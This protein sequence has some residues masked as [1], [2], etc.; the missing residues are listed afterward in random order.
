[1]RRRLIDQ[2]IR[3]ACT[4]ASSDL[5]PQNIEST[6]VVHNWSQRPKCSGVRGDL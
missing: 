1:M 6:V 4:F 5:S 3:A 2:A